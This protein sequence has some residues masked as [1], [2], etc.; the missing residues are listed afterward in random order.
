M[1]ATLVQRIVV[2]DAVPENAPCPVH[3]PPTTEVAL[4]VNVP[5]KL[6][7][8]TVPETVPFQAAVAHVPLTELPTCVRLVANAAAVNSRLSIVPDQVPAT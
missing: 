3:A 1:N 7:E 6:V 5:V 8:S 2:D 4:N